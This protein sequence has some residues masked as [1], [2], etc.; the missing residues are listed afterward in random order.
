MTEN[1]FKKLGISFPGNKPKSS[2]VVLG[3]KDI[4]FMRTH[5]YDNPKYGKQVKLFLYG[6]H[7]GQYGITVSMLVPKDEFADTEAN[8]VETVDD[9]DE[10]NFD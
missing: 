7:D 6:D 4:E 2:S 9:L 10:V 8:E 1:E 5:M 3:E